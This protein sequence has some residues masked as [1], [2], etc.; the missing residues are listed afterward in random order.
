MEQDFELIHPAGIRI[1][2]DLTHAA[3]LALEAGR[4][5]PHHDMG[6]GWVW[7]RLP[8]F[9][10]GDVIVAVSLGFHQGVLEQISFSDANSKYGS[11]WN[12]WSEEQEQLRAA[13]IGNWLR[14]RGY[15]PGTYGWGSVW[16]AY[17]Q[18]DASGSAGVRYAP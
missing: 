4:D 15:P 18:K 2:R 11:N 7:V 12:D 8:A 5:L 13:S 10:D 17:D 3:L 1:A 9:Q 16:A 14:D 6:T